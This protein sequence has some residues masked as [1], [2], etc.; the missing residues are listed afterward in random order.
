MI[1]R[2]E[3]WVVLG[4]YEDGQEI[5]VARA[6]NEW[7]LR[8]QIIE[9]K[10]VEPE[11]PRTWRDRITCPPQPGT[12]TTS[13]GRIIRMSANGKVEE[14]DLGWFS[15]SGVEHVL[16][17]HDPDEPC[18]I[19]ERRWST[20]TYKGQEIDSY[21]IRDLLAPLDPFPEEE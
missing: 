3:L 20:Y 13:A 6:D 7:P 19:P 4:E 1:P 2:F 15:S 18:P 17:I 10:H 8:E 12:S 5:C 9:T 21:F 16:S 11:V 14:V